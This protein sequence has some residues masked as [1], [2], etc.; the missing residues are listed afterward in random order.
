MRPFKKISE[1]LA[2]S[3]APAFQCENNLE[4]K[5]MALSSIR[6]NINR[7]QISSDDRSDAM[8]KLHTDLINGA[9]E[10]GNMNVTSCSARVL[11]TGDTLGR[12]VVAEDYAIICPIA[13]TPSCPKFPA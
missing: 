9:L 11:K 4:I 2:H 10:I 12:A 8:R 5:E 1:S 7:P 13:G 6:K 3:I